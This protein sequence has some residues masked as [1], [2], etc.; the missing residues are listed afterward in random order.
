MAATTTCDPPPGGPLCHRRHAALVA[1]ASADDGAQPRQY[2]APRFH[3]GADMPGGSRPG[4]GLAEMAIADDFVQLPIGQFEEPLGLAVAVV[5]QP[6]GA[7]ARILEG[8][9]D[10]GARGAH[11][12]TGP[13][14][15]V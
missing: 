10:R 13:T 15:L 7:K 12:L 1:R 14:A 2:S 4:D 8:D 6:L 3:R 9:S 5:L 11:R